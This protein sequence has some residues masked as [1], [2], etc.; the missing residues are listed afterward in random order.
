MGP[1]STQEELKV[2]Q[3]PR[4]C[5]QQPSIATDQP[6]PFNQPKGS[7]SQDD[8]LWLIMQRI[9]QT[10]TEESLLTPC[11][12]PRKPSSLCWPCFPRGTGHCHVSLQHLPGSTSTSWLLQFHP[13]RHPS[14]LY[15]VVRERAVCLEA[16]SL[17]VKSRFS[18]CLFMRPPFLKF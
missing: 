10:T 18:H 9:K 12:S 1:F 16:H 7:K 13:A 17:G 6:A 11:H 5:C 4:P 2:L 15:R 3:P 8:A 14:L